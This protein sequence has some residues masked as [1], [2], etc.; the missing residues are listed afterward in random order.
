MKK[1]QTNFYTFIQ[2]LN[3]LVT[4][5]YSELDADDVEELHDLYVSYKESK[6]DDCKEFIEFWLQD[7]TPDTHTHYLRSKKVH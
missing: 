4:P 6:F 7:R 5:Q 2:L 1:K 3:K